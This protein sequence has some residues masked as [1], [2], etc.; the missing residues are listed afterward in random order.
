MGCERCHLK[1][2]DGRV[3]ARPALSLVAVVLMVGLVGVRFL[4]GR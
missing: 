4:E 3:F 2:Y 1:R